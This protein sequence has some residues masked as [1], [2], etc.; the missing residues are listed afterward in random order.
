MD[1][2]YIS[3]RYVV[4]V[5]NE[6][7]LVGHVRDSSEGTGPDRHVQLDW[8]ADEV[9]AVESSHGPPQGHGGQHK[10]G[11]ASC[12]F[13]IEPFSLAKVV[14]KKVT[15]VAKAKARDLEFQGECSMLCIA[16]TQ[17]SEVLRFV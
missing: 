5:E 7:V 1:G 16:D 9:R 14:G 6:A 3:G 17:S 11:G 10:S 2:G 15:G 12:S 13:R 4:K 8:V